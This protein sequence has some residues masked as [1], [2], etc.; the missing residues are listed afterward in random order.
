VVILHV[1]AGASSS[2][3]ISDQ[4]QVIALGFSALLS[5]MTASNSSIGGPAHFLAAT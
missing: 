3:S 1:L 4:A 5:E 2:E